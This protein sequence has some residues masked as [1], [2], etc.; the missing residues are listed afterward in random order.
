MTNIIVGTAGHI[1]HGK[2][3]LVRALT[4]IETDRLAEEKRRGIS[5]DLG[6]AHLELPGGVRLGFVDVPGHERFVRN[7]LAGAGGIDLV[8]LVVAAD[9]SIKP[10]TR[11]HFDICRLLG[12]RRG[13]VALTKIDLVDR[14]IVELVR[15]EVEDF[16]ADSFLEGSPVVPVSAVTGEGLEALKEALAAAAGS[17]E[18]KDSTRRL[19]LPIDRSFTMHGHG[20]VVTGTL[21]SGRVKVE[22]EVEIHPSGRRV[23]VRGIQVHGQPVGSATAGQRTA[24]NLAGVQASELRRGMML[25]EPGLFQ[26]VPEIDCEFDLLPSAKPLKHRAPVHFH[27]WT[28]ETEAEFRLL[29]GSTVLDPGGRAWARFLLRDP[30]PL[31]P[32]DRFIVRMFSPV[33]TIGGGAVIDIGPFPRLKRQAAYE[34][35]VRLAQASP[36]E[37]LGLL[38]AEQPFGLPL[39]ALEARTGLRR[40]QIERMIPPEV[41]VFPDPRPWLID[42]ASL[43]RSGARLRETLAAFHRQNPVQPGMAKEDLRARGLAGAQPFLLDAILRLDP[44]IITEGEVVRLKSHQPRFQQ[45]EEAALARIEA[46]F[47]QGGLTVPATPEVLASC[48]VDPARARTL[49]QLLLKQRRLIRLGDDLVFHPSALDSLKQMLVGRRGERF[50][51][52]V[53]KDWTGISRKYAIPLLEYLDRERVTRREGD[54]RVIL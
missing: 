5:I 12:I 42:K 25:T 16:V 20:T 30:L 40:E 41:Q 8:L 3:A 10:Q 37:R 23:R 22:Q 35:A 26:A 6:F 32:G 48:G 17:V 52:P 13:L 49:L 54:S 9:E 27:A 19:R 28:A 38:V 1:D 4:G 47:Q 21:V 45:D 7:M 24:L 44:G 15:M 14:D 31:L 36:S 33:V 2:T 50:S 39:E 51:V 29:D 11:E 34:R 18:P 53:F 46:A 43:A